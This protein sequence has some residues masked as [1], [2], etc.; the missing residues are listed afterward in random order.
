M[1]REKITYLGQSGFLVEKDSSTLLIDPNSKKAG[2][3]MGDVVFTTHYH[4]DHTGGVPTFLKRNPEA[5]FICNEQVADRFQ[6]WE[7][8]IILAIPGETIEQNGWKLRFIEGQHGLF[9]NVKNTGV[10]IQ[11]NS[12]S[13]GHAGDTVDFQGFS[14]EK[15]TIFAIPIS[16]IFTASPKRALKEL[17]SF[18][19][20]PL[21]IIV[22][23]HWLWRSPHG[24]CKRFHRTFPGNHCV[25]PQKGELVEWNKIQNK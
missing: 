23:I 6:Q 14:Q 4:Q 11:S 3:F 1:D 25:I 19:T 9:S 21:P 8:R 17:K 13:F 5:V 20:F 24:F 18:T 2:D 16:G 10:I 22:P 12:V 7:E 15:L